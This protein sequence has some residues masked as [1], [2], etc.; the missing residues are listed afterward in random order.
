L[1]GQP[2]GTLAANLH[3]VPVGLAAADG[4]TRALTPQTCLAAGDKLTVVLS[5]TDLQSLLQREST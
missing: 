2:I 3:F 5:Q 1:A 4:S